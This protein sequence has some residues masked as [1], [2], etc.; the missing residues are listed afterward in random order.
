MSAPPPEATGQSVA[1]ATD[2]LK[3]L[4]IDVIERHCSGRVWPAA[5]TLL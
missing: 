5:L 3:A 2:E 1:A 4:G